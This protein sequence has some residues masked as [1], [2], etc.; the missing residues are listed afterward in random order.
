MVLLARMNFNIADDN[1][2]HQ[3][4]EYLSSAEQMCTQVNFPAGYRWLSGSYY[5]LGATM[6]KT[7]LFSSAMYPLRKSCS[8]LEKDTERINTNEGRLQLCKRYEILG[9]CCQKNERYEDAIKAYR[10]ALKR[11]PH[12]VVEKFTS[13]A[14][15]TAVST[16]IETDPLVP[17]LIDRFLRSSII[18]PAQ[19]EIRFASQVMELFTLTPIQ[20]GIIY[21]CELKVWN[22]L[23]LKMNVTKFQLSI[24]HKLLEIYNGHDYPIRRAR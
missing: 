22:F 15:N 10:F 16:I 13:R 5:N 23:A 21:E 20:Q 17:K 18:D 11:V 1:T 2:H 19:S 3:A 24:I 9:T 12:Y 8:L 7:E 14:D 6:I 4:Y